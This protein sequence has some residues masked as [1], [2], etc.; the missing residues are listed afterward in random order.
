MTLHIMQGEGIYF[1]IDEFLTF[2]LVI[3]V[4]EH[5]SYRLLTL[6]STQDL[7]CITYVSE[8]DMVKSFLKCVI[9]LLSTETTKNVFRLSFFV[10]SRCIHYNFYFRNI[11][12]T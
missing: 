12:F 5:S 1:L 10:F 6:D 8:I 7:F 4:L 3:K 9:D 11:R 2:Q